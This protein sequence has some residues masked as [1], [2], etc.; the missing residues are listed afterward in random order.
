MKGNVFLDYLQ[1]ALPAAALCGDDGGEE[2]AQ[3]KHE[4]HVS[5]GDAAYFAG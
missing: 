4:I 1:L 5:P 3:A 2:Y